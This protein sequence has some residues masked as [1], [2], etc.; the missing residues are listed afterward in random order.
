MWR[1]VDWA[2]NGMFNN[3]EFKTYEDAWEYIYENVDDSED[4]N[5]Y[6]DYFA[7]KTGGDQSY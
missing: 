6:D 2:N 4:I 3:K 1:I 7:I 5:A